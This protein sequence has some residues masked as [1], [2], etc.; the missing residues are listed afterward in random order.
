[1]TLYKWW[2]F[3]CVVFVLCATPG[4]N[5]LHILVRSVRLGARR[6]TAAMA[7]CLASL[8]CILLASVGGLSAV[9]VASPYL[10]TMVRYAGV[11]YLV[12]IGIK[13]WRGDDTPFDIGSNAAAIV[14]DLSP[15]TLF[16]GGFLVG[17]SNPKALVFCSAFLPQFIDDKMPQ[18]PQFLILIVTFA[19]SELL[20]YGVYALGGQKL[21]SYLT[22]PSFKRLFN[23]ITGGIFIGFGAALLGART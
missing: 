16:R 12:Y 14:S 19:L 13:A 21:A 3:F 1:M 8:L 15:W 6:S 22:R 18:A 17:I 10:F 9:L 20:W 5:M 23:R 2:L 11:A 4:P 7:G